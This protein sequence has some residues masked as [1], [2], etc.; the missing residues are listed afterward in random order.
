MTIGKHLPGKHKLPSKLPVLTHDTVAHGCCKRG[1]FIWYTHYVMLLS[2]ASHEKTIS[3]LFCLH[4]IIIHYH[5]HIIT[6]I[7]SSHQFSLL[8]PSPSEF[9]P[10]DRLVL[11]V[12]WQQHPPRISSI[13]L[14]SANSGTTVSTRAMASYVVHKKTTCIRWAI[15]CVQCWPIKICCLWWGIWSGGLPE[16]AVGFRKHNVTGGGWWWLINWIPEPN[17]WH[18]LSQTPISAQ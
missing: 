8:Y 15:F 3:P 18:H 4:Y 9:S 2:S 13:Y 1:W 11:L 12:G 17:L 6:P 16:Q 14:C 5:H 10:P 7:T